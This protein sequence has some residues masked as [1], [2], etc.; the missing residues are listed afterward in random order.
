MRMT[1]VGIRPVLRG[2]SKRMAS[3]SPKQFDIGTQDLFLSF[4]ARLKALKCVIS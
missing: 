3:F 1:Q 2:K 4:L